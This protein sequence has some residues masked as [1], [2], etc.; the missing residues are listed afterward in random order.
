MAENKLSWTEL[1]RAL[2]TRAGVSEKEAYLFLSA[3]NA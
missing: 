3:F 2:A 1:R